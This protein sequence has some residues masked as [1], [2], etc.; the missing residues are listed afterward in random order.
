MPPL[1]LPDPAPPAEPGP[2][3]PDSTPP[4]KA[5]DS[6]VALQTQ[7]DA[8]SGTAPLPGVTPATPAPSRVAAPSSRLPILHERFQMLN[9]VGYGSY[10]MVFRGLDLFTNRPVG[11]K[12]LRSD[13]YGDSFIE[14]QWAREQELAK[15][16]NIS[17]AP[18]GLAAGNDY[19]NNTRV[20]YLVTEFVAGENLK[21]WR[22]RLGDQTPEP[23]VVA[24][25]GRGVAQA[26]CE[27]KALGVV[28]RD[29]KPGNVMRTSEGE[30]RVMDFG[31]H[32]RID[33]PPV[34]PSEK[35]VGTPQYMP[36]EVL[37]GAEGDF[38]SDVYCLGL[39][40]FYVITGTAPFQ[41]KT[42][43]EVL[44]KHRRE[45]LPPLPERWRRSRLER[46]IEAMAE[47]DPALRPGIE[48]IREELDDIGLQEL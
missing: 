35:M 40:L 21:D 44:A 3:A 18:R 43:Q 22:E 48:E 2:S 17:G 46:L 45:P 13:C 7:R 25:I 11:I 5:N 20:S 42:V 37:A 15:Q 10:G 23:A 26:L 32:R 8:T 34:A 30:V 38:A 4:P 33:D 12:I 27:L 1:T 14:A 29:I 28:H 36:P 39:T 41:G 47:K 9:I 19:Y 24:S 6:T 16:L 31:L